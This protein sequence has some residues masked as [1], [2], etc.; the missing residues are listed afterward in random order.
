MGAFWSQSFFLP[1]PTLTEKN[2][3]DQ[4]GKIF[5]VTGGYAG[6]GWQ[7]T[8]ILYGANATVYVA[9]RSPE[10]GAKAIEEF[11]KAH[12]NS[13]GRLEFLMLDLA[14]LS[15]I[16][17]SAEEFM[18]KEKRLDVLWNNAGVMWPPR[19]SKSA[20]GFELQMGTNC[21]GHFLFTELLYPVLASTAATAPADSVRVCWAGSLGIDLSAPKHGITLDTNGAPIAKWK[22]SQ[23]YHYAMSKAGN[24]FYGHEFSVHHPNSRIVSLCF[25]PGNLETEL[26]RHTSF[27]GQS[28]FS[29]L[30]LYPA[31]YGG[32]TELWSGLSEE[33]TTK[34]NGTYVAPWGRK[35]PMRSDVAASL[36]TKEE[37][38]NGV[39]KTF[40]DWSVAETKKYM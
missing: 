29:K 33:I 24:F 25:N 40:W 39:S 1:K 17:A 10:K 28:F 15:T 12:P 31:I 21:L 11:K 23:Q 27:P 4:S 7:L 8:K 20:Q 5:I 2:V 37:G 26:Q 16:K 3:K 30:M 22:G 6:V 34:D 9:G 19:G 36:K 32:Y 13:N 14:D 18:S 35:H 38:G